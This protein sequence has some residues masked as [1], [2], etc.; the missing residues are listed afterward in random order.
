MSEQPRVTEQQSPQAGIG[1]AFGQLSEQTA[2]LVRREI[3][4][5]RQEMWA[6]GKRSAPALALLAGSGVAGVLALASSYRFS[7]RL[8]ERRLS[9]AT[10]ALVGTAM[11]GGA[12]AYAALVGVRQLRDAPMPLPTDTIRDTGLRLSD[13]VAAAHD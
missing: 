3:D 13:G 10:A 2:I 11:Y 1:E 8:L 9:P 5:A 12:S 4:A 6:K 7:L